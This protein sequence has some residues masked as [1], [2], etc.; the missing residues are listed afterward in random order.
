MS[1]L[2]E[3]IKVFEIVSRKNQDEITKLRKVEN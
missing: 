1:C 2:E 3:N